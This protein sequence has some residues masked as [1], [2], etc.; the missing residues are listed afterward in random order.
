MK[1]PT[2]QQVKEKGFNFAH[3][4]GWI[5][6]MAMDAMITSPNTTIPASLLQ[7]VSPEIVRILTAK[8]AAR[9]VFAEKKVGDW[10]TASYLF[11]V[12]EMVGSTGP[13]SD[14]GDGPSSDSNTEWSVRDQY[15]FQT[16]ITYGDLEADR[17][18]SAKID[19]IAQKQRAAASAINID[20]NNF[21]LLGVS[22]KRIYGMLNDPNLPTAL[23]PATV[24]S[25]VTWVQKM[26][27]ADGGGTLAV[28]NDVLATFAQLQTQLGG[29]VDENSNL[30]LLLSPARAVA[31]NQSTNFNVSARQMLM[32]NFPNLEIITI[33][34]LS[35]VNVG[36]TMILTVSEVSGIE[37]GE[38]G[39]G[40]KIRQGRLVA[41]TSHYRQKFSA[42]TYGF[43][44]KIP[45]AFAVMTGI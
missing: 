7:Y 20:A 3:A 16:T 10:T 13:Y 41:D 37:V 22:G 39:F 28:Y 31:L 34:Q 27:L 8:E 26:A 32:T 40:E 42:S 33:P 44:N 21:Y 24:D 11:P 30:K 2:L 14:Y 25:A 18:A 15:I 36:E 38:L 9:A 12:E 23:S 17:S 4:K 29:L 5:G 43:V 45:A 19:L 6:E 1:Y 35:S